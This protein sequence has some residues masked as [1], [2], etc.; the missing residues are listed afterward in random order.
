M[1]RNTSNNWNVD[2][3]NI[4]CNTSTCIKD[5]LIS[6][7]DHIKNARHKRA[8]TGLIFESLRSISGKHDH[9]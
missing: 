3:H 1:W 9:K 5:K 2:D 7:F 6:A 8:D 4:N